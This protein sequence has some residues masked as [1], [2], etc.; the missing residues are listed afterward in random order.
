M[1]KKSK[2]FG[3]E[4]VVWGKIYSFSKRKAS[5]PTM[6]KTLWYLCKKQHRCLE[7]EMDKKTETADHKR[8]LSNQCLN[9][10]KTKC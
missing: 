5:K 9:R 4:E 8:Y 1:S 2:T 3:K 6:S 7:K 10:P